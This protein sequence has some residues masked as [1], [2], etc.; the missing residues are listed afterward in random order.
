MLLLDD[1][2]DAAEI[3]T[4]AWLGTLL[5]DAPALSP[6]LPPLLVSLMLMLVWKKE[7]VLFALDGVL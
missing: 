4:G 1:V 7:V 5:L 6:P 2:V 3:A